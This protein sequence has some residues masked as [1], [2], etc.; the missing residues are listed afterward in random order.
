MATDKTHRLV[1]TPKMSLASLAEY[2]CASERSRRTLIRSC[3]YRPIAKVVQHDDAKVIISKD[4]IS[5]NMTREYLL[6][7]AERIRAKIA[8]S[9]FD[10]EVNDHNADYLIRFAHVLSDLV[11]PKAEVI[12]VGDRIKLETHGVAISVDMSFRLRRKTKT[13]KIKV[14]GAMMRYS[15]GKPTKPE[16]CVMQASLLF[17][18]LGLP[19]ILTDDEAEVEKA[20]SLTIDAYSGESYPAAGDAASRFANAEAACE[21]IANSW[22][23]ITPPPN[24]IF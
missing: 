4:F 20:M 18:V 6:E 10:A 19:G 23:K 24:S 14:G 9:D 13:N 12:S 7:E 2:M 15:K 22:E 1:K 5:G 21:L 3:K 11:L 17:G 8:D 16:L